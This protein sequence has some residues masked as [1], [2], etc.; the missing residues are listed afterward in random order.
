MIVN[1]EGNSNPNTISNLIKPFRFHACWLDH[2]EVDEVIN[3]CWVMNDNLISNLNNYKK[4]ILYWN[5]SVFGNI[6]QNKISLWS[7]WMT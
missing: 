3:G 5:K 4:R 6:F 1:T 2:P 7:V